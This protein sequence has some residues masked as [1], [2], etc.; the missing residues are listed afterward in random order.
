[1]EVINDP[2]GRD[3][4]PQQAV[5]SIGNFDGVHL[6]HRAVIRSTVERARELDTS[7]TLMTFDPHPVSLLRPE[8]APE[9]LT[10]M[11]Q[12]LEL[13][14]QTG[15]DV[16]TVVPFT[17]R[18]ARMSAVTFIERVLVERFAVR[19]LFVGANFRFGAD[20]EGDVNLLIKEGERLGF[21]ARPWPTVEINGGVVSSTRVRA[22]VADGKVELAGRMLGRA[23][24]GD[25][26]VLLGK[27]LGRRLGFPT[28]NVVLENELIPAE[29]VYISAVFIP[30]FQRVFPSVTNIGVRPTVYEDSGVTI[31]THL[32][33]FTADVYSERVRL[34]FLERLRDEKVFNSTLQLVAQVGRDV[35][36]TRLWFLNH[37][38]DGLKL[39]HP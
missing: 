12:R 26:K 28:L 34:F 38:V 27:R 20:R 36:K 29:G 17:H 25:G 19:E 5:L 8:E 39:V 30:S 18:V 23:L 15:L 21:D 16:T 3:D 4:V 35:E 1:M 31:E 37:P 11:E 22:A 33:D 2:L 6:G 10:T 9:L 32:L 13:L 7:A 24:H 14:A